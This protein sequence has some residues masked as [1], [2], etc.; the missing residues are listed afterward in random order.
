MESGAI[1]S[2]FTDDFGPLDEGWIVEEDRAAFAGNKI[3][4]LVKAQRGHQAEGSKQLAAI[5]A[6]QA[7]GIVFDQDNAVVLAD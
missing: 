1:G 4:R 3:L 7:M 6:E 5:F 2:F